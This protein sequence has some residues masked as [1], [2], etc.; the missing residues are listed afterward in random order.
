LAAVA[1]SRLPWPLLGVAALGLALVAGRAHAYPTT[2]NPSAIDATLGES[3]RLVAYQAE[4]QGAQL[5]VTLYW[6][7]LQSPDQDY[8]VFVHAVGDDG[9]M[10]AQHDGQPGLEFSPTTRWVAGELMVDRHYLALPPGPVT[11]YA[12][13]YTLPEVTNLPVR[14]DGHEVPDGRV[15]VGRW[16]AP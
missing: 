2:Q 5:E 1:R 3:L 9:E 13:M 4:Q 10:L 8:R 15:L 12:G 16:S 14:Q 6:L 11:L 7:A